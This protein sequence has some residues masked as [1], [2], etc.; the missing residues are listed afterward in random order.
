MWEVCILSATT[1]GENRGA[2]V[3][4]MALLYFRVQTRDV[5][6]GIAGWLQT[7]EYLKL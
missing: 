7:I 6:F 4:I 2:V 5:L 1:K 3:K